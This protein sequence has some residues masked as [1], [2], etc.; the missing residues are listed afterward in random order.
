MAPGDIMVKVNGKSF[1]CEECGANVFHHPR[2]LN[3]FP[4]GMGAWKLET[5][6]YKC[7]SCGVRYKGE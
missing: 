7:N 6:T 2:V 5:N 3:T 4:D 1:R